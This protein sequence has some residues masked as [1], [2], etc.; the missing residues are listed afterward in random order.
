[1][2][3]SIWKNDFESKRESVMVFISKARVDRCGENLRR[4]LG[5]GD[6]VDSNECRRCQLIALRG[7]LDRER[8]MRH[9]KGCPEDLD[10]Y[11]CPPLHRTRTSSE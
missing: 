4:D 5:S 7:Q 9:C 3:S 10:E 2:Q 6:V 8:A 11:E 1:M